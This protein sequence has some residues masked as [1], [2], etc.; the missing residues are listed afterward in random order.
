MAEPSENPSSPSG[1]VV[2]DSPTTSERSHGKGT[3][4]ELQATMI[5]VLKS[6]E[7]ISLETKGEVSRLCMLTGNLQRR[8]DLEFSTPKGA[9][10]GGMSQSITRNEPIIPL[11]PL[12]EEGRDRGKKKVIPEGSQPVIEPVPEN[13]FP[14]FPLLSFNNRRQ[15]EPE[16]MR[17]GLAAMMGETSEKG[18]TTTISDKPSPYRP[19]P[20][21]SKGGGSNWRKPE[22]R[23]EVNAGNDRS[24]KI[25][26]A[27]LGHN[28]NSATQQLREEFAELRRTVTQNAQPRAR[29]VFRITYQKPYPEYIDEMNPFPLNFK[30][31]AFPTFTDEDSSVSSRDHI[32][33]FSN[34]CVAY[35]DNPN[36]KLRLFGNSLAGLTSQWYS[37]LPPNSIAN[38]GQMEMAFHEQFYRIEPELTINDL[39]EVKQYDH[40]STEDFMMRF[41]RTRM[42]CQ[43]PVNQAQLISIAQRA[44][45]LPL[46]KRFYDAQFNELQE[47]VIAATKYERLLQEEQQVKHTS[48]VPH[49][50]KSKA[51]IHHVEVGKTRPEREDGHEEDRDE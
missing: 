28:D 42:R 37:L 3:N 5:Q 30:M 47:L 38:W 46:R 22:P 27:I 12:L 14:S 13:E 11:F 34:H 20:M 44:L 36:Y 19:P 21:V 32:F 45:K 51:T 50:Y 2:S 48:K 4:E 35:E 18:T 29:P 6:M 26:S 33:K 17:H 9:Q 43:F 41:R 49:F 1:Q 8:L 15:S 31:P 10:E 40:E 39:E 23:R 24:P 25:E 16:K 7:M